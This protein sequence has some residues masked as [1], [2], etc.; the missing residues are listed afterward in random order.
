MASRTAPTDVI[1]LAQKIRAPRKLAWPRPFAN[2]LTSWPPSTRAETTS[3]VTRA[4]GTSLGRNSSV[5]SAMRMIEQ[6]P[7]RV[8]RW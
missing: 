8:T 7:I 5:T 6:S 4:A 3:R 1:R 2:T